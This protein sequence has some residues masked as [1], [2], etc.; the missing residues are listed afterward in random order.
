MRSNNLQAQVGFY[1]SVRVRWMRWTSG[2]LENGEAVDEKDPVVNSSRWERSCCKQQLITSRKKILSARLWQKAAILINLACRSLQVSLTHCAL[3]LS[4]IIYEIDYN[5]CMI[6]NNKHTQR[7]NTCK[8]QRRL[9]SYF[10]FS[11][12]VSLTW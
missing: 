11:F 2:S 9:I 10:L 8:M 5:S 3:S 6:K 1:P 7:K 12:D 4:Y